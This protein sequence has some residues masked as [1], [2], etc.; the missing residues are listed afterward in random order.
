VNSA[1]FVSRLRRSMESIKEA[2]ISLAAF[3]FSSNNLR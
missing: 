3:S 1:E 2:D